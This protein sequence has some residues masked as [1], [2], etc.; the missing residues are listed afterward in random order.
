MYVCMDV[1]VQYVCM[2]LV[3]MY[4]TYVCMDFQSNENNEV[5]MHYNILVL[6]SHH[7]YIHTY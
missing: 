2:Y 7:I 4:C 5:D 3:Y 1:Y 6:I